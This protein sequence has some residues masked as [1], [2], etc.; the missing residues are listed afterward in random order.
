MGNSIIIPKS[1]PD[2]IESIRMVQ[3]SSTIKICLA[4]H[5][6]GMETRIGIVKTKQKIRQFLKEIYIN[7]D[8]VIF[9]WTT[10]GEQNADIIVN[11]KDVSH[12]QPVFDTVVSL[13][14]PFA[15]MPSEDFKQMCRLLKPGG[16]ALSSSLPGKIGKRLQNMIR[17]R[18]TS[19]HP[20][21]E[22]PTGTKLTPLY[23]TNDP[24]QIFA[25]FLKT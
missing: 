3:E 4:C 23:S 22:F 8:D 5:E 9:T 11:D 19:G 24:E 21:L 20:D 17:I 6:D 25:V 7:H 1:D 12:I 2:I 13:G 14:C 18:K 10:W 16:L 15:V